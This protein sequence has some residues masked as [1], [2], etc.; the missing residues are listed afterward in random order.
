MARI[1]GRGWIIGCCIII[2]ATLITLYF[3]F[4]PTNAQLAPKCPFK[5][6]T[7][8]DCPACGNQRSLH[9]LLHGDILKAIM[10]NPFLYI[11]LPFM[12]ILVYVTI[13]DK[14]NSTRLRAVMFHKYSIYS[15]IAIFIVWWIFRNTQMWHNIYAS[16]IT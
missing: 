1:K 13:V 12:G 15:Y 3:I 11:A 14:N 6:L 7:G 16:V 9:S 5:L 2:V 8:L 4:D 10:L